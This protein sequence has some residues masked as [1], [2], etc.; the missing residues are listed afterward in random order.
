M[1]GSIYIAFSYSQPSS[2]IT[3]LLWS[4]LVCS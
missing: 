4:L 2:R 1:S 3:T